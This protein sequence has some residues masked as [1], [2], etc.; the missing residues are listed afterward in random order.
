[1][2]RGN[3]MSGANN[4]PLGARGIP[5]EGSLAQAAA[6]LSGHSLLNPEYLQSAQTTSAPAP[7]GSRFGPVAGE[8]YNY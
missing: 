4:I 5:R 8:T 2:N 7:S 6:S 3:S 1:M